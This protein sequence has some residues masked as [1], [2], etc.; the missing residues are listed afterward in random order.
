LRG[1][2]RKEVCLLVRRINGGWFYVEGDNC[3]GEDGPVVRELGRI[4]VG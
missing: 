1:L 4:V 2:R 3:F